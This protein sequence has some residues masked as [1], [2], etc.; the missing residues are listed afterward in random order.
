MGFRGVIRPARGVALAVA[1]SLAVVAFGMPAQTAE[2]REWTWK[3]R[4]IQVP[5]LERT[6]TVELTAA[7]PGR[8]YV[9][10][11]AADDAP[12]AVFAIGEAV[13]AK[14]PAA[15]LRLIEGIENVP[16]HFVEVSKGRIRV[17][18]TS[19]PDT[20]LV[21]R[22]TVPAGTAV[23]IERRGTMV[24]AATVSGDALVVH[25]DK[26]RHP[27]AAGKNWSP[28]SVLMRSEPVAKVTEP[29]PL[30]NGRY[31]VT[32]AAMARNLLQFALPD[33]GGRPVTS[34]MRAHVRLIVNTQGRVE[35]VEKISG[36][37]EAV[38]AVEAAVRR[39][40]FR[41]F[42]VGGQAVVA[43]GTLF[44]FFATDGRVSSPILAELGQ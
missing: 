17:T 37:P 12:E 34:E 3:Y 35:H 38:A 20:A 7:D 26:L 43:E 15:P 22:G 33:L 13:I 40:R 18:G 30:R 29:L 39:W 2:R 14:G 21:V 31:L 10:G 27:G 44:F 6:L 19:R 24:A 8:E 5:L 4:K 32:P 23:K 11:I 41:P 42:V 9:V 16:E 28:I 36:N 1:G 25:N